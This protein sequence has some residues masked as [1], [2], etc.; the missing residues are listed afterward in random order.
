MTQ[1]LVVASSPHFRAEGSTAAIMRDVLIALLPAQIAAIYFFGAGALLLTVTCAA[2]SML[3]EYLYRRLMHLDGTVGDLSA[4]VTGV[5]L[6]YNLPAGIPLWMAVIGC[7]AAVIV[8]KQLFGGLGRN[9]AN[10]AIV[11]R[12]V[13]LLSF[14]TQMTS[15]PIPGQDGV[16]GATPLGVVAAMS[17]P[18]TASEALKLPGYLDMFLGNI[19]GSMGET[20]AL[21]LLIGF[22]YLLARRVI[23]ATEPLAFMGTVFIL[24]WALGADP[25]FHLLAGGLMLG[26]IFMG[27]DYVT[28]PTTETGKLIFGVGAGILTVVI[29]LYGSYPEG[30]SFA[31]LLMNII[32]PHIDNLTR[33]KAFGGVEE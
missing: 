24:S 31:I 28:T 20:S 2:A 18:E 5:L 11:G 12:I 22:G 17:N 7:F 6:A 14:A 13:L 9:F 19:G 15:W 16:T 25:V 3:F 32:T 29:R 10:P 27:T 30:V 23:T 8:I 4:A 1:N 26:A 33:I 21:A